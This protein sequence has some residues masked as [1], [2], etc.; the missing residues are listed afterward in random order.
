MNDATHA[1]TPAA[2]SRWNSAALREMHREL[3]AMMNR[4]PEDSDAASMLFHALEALEAAD[5]AM[6][7]RQA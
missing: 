4:Q 5:F 2:V 1:F 3:E 7:G 6:S